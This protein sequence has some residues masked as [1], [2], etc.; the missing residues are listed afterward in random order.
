MVRLSFDCY[1][2]YEYW[3]M[4]QLIADALVSTGL[5]KLGYTYVNI[6]MF[7]WFYHKYLNFLWLW[8]FLI[9][10]PVI[11]LDDCWA[12]MARDDKVVLLSALL[13]VDWTLLEKIE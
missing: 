13:I 3:L 1:C 12:E 7:L 9:T 6:G 5:S 2:F 8:G 4:F 11:C 10:V